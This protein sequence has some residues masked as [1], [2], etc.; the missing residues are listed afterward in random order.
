MEVGRGRTRLPE[1]MTRPWTR[2]SRGKKPRE[3]ESAG[4]L[5]AAHRRVKAEVSGGA[6]SEQPPGPRYLLGLPKLRKAIKQ[7]TKVISQA[8]LLNLL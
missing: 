8:E 4:T 1:G 5:P 6:G 2:A 3:S 7:D